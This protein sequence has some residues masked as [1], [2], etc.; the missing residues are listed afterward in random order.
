MKFIYAVVLLC[1]WIPQSFAI[2]LDTQGKV[3]NLI[4]YSGPET[5]LV[6]LSNTGA[7]V[8]GCSD[9]S[10]FAISSGISAEA[11]ARMYSMLLAARESGRVITVSYSDVGGC[12]PWG[13]SPNVYRKIVRL[14]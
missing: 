1:L 4:T 8:E 7:P 11:R 3:T 13:A 5:V 10:T 14:R 6:Q 9:K 2:W 12:E